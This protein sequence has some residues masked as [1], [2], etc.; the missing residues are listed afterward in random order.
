MPEMGTCDLC[1]ER[2]VVHGNTGEGFGRRQMFCDD[3]CVC[4][5]HCPGGKYYETPMK[6]D[7]TK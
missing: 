5:N 6:V 1:G 3:C 7:K 2:K 4:Y